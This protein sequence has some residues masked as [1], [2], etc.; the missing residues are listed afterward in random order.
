MVTS[1]FRYE[2]STA[3]ARFVC[4]AICF[5]V[6]PLFLHMVMAVFRKWSGMLSRVMMFMGSWGVVVFLFPDFCTSMIM[7][8]FSLRAARFALISDSR[9][10]CFLSMMSS[11]LNS[12]TCLNIN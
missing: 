8:S 6:A 2:L 9:L 10:S 4:S 5:A 11:L 3:L 12:F 1:W 7:S